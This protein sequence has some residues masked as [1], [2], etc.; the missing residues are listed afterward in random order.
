[1]RRRG[2]TLIELVAVMALVSAV[3]LAAVATYPSWNRIHS[4]RAA[5]SILLGE[6]Q[7]AREL[8]LTQN[9]YVRVGVTNC[10]RSL[11]RPS[12]GLVWISCADPGDD[13][14]EP[15]HFPISMGK[16]NELPRGVFF[17]LSDADRTARVPAEHPG[18]SES[19]D[20]PAS[21]TFRP[22]GACAVGG[23]W[24]DEWG[25]DEVERTFR[26]RYQ[27]P[28]GRSDDSTAPDKAHYLF[29]GFAVHRLTGL[30]RVVPAAHDE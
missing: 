7:K 1:M 20:W 16:T 25:D 19:S 15:G 27:H 17:V 11:P 6:F 21:V 4:M 23:D 10:V 13:D 8:A 18:A 3:L 28:S 9:L 30:A 5:E 24:G 2:Y 14:A 29:Q 26:I 22:D 12:S